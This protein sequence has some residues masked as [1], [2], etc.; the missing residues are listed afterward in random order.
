[1]KTVTNAALSLNP[2]VVSERPS[3]NAS[4]FTQEEVENK[5]LHVDPK[6][7]DLE[8]PVDTMTEVLE[9]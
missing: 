1:M 7:T 4:V 2:P 3:R 5:L 9:S 6:G 8:L